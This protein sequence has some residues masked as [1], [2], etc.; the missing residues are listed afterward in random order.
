MTTATALPR[1]L[2]SDVVTAH[3]QREFRIDPADRAVAIALLAVRALNRGE[4]EQVVSLNP[5][6]VTASEAIA[7]L[8]LQSFLKPSSLRLLTDETDSRGDV[9]SPHSRANE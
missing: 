3:L 9:P 7:A 5:I 8:R 6:P 4:T 1:T 2:L